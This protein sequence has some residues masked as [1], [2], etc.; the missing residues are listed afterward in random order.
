MRNFKRLNLTPRPG[1]PEPLYEAPAWL[2]DQ[3]LT[4]LETVLAPQ[5]MQ[6]MID[7][8]PVIRE[9][10]RACRHDL[11]VRVLD[12]GSASGAGANLLGQ[13]YASPMRGPR[14]LVDAME[15]HPWM[16]RYA[17]AK[18]RF[19]RRYIVADVMNYWPEEP[20][21][22]VICSHTLEHV[23]RWEPF[24]QHLRELATCSVLLY[25]PWK[26][27][28]RIQEHVLTV[29]EAFLSRVGVQ[30]HWIVD[31]PA[32]YRGAGQEARCVAFVLPGA[33]DI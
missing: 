2:P 23:S 29:D 24:I 6:F 14:L 15:L 10:L 27:E 32:W 12:V 25:T 17:R 31:S 3:D 21:D 26:E 33:A 28:P 11:P 16:A 30:K 5:S 9:L 19:I 13:L 1:D 8:L 7:L 22:L 20:W 18:L 4:W